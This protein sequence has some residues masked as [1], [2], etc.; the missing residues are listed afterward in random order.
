MKLNVQNSLFNTTV[1]QFFFFLA[2]LQKKTTKLV[3]N[4]IQILFRLLAIVYSAMRNTN[5]VGQTHF[6][7]ETR[8]RFNRFRSALLERCNAAQYKSHVSSVRISNKPL[9]SRCYFEDFHSNNSLE[10]HGSGR[11]I[12]LQNIIRLTTC[13]YISVWLVEK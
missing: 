1:K 13:I 6:R 8:V 3:W 4:V 12:K 10:N 5:C 2:N 11:L 9:S 7:F